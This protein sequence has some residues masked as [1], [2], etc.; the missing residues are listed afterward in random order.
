L[1]EVK[2]ITS[3]AKDDGCRFA[4]PILQ[5]GIIVA[6]IVVIGNAAGAV[7]RLGSVDEIDAFVKPL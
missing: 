1:N 6:R 5:T 7:T 2:P 4:L 3:F